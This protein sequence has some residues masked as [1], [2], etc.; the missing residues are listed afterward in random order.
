MPARYLLKEIDDRPV[1]IFVAK[2]GKNPTGWAVPVQRMLTVLQP[3]Q[4]RT[5]RGTAARVVHNCN[6]IQFSD[7]PARL[8]GL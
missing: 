2:S 4:T 5:L 1:Q 3:L 6:W 8:F 7:S